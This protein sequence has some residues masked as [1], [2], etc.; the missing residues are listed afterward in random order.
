M[1]TTLA[2]GWSQS[3]FEL[4]HMKL[5]PLACTPLHIDYS[6]TESAGAVVVAAPPWSSVAVYMATQLQCSPN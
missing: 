2:R 3:Q 1:G 6:L 4:L 5:A